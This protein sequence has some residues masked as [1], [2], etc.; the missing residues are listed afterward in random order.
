MYAAG[1][2]WLWRRSHND[3][4][5]DAHRFNRDRVG[6]AG[7]LAI[8]V[9]HDDGK[10]VRADLRCLPFEPAIS[11]QRDPR[12]ELAAHLVGIAAAATGGAQLMLYVT[13]DCK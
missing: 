7:G 1:P 10:G 6:E 13:A 4:H 5:E 9:G 3:R 8:A 2:Y 11:A 12:R